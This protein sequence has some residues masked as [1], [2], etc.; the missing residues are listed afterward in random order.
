MTT[1]ITGQDVRVYQAM[2]IR[3]ALNMYIRTGMKANTAYTPKNMLATAGHIVGKAYGKA[4]NQT[5]Q[6][7]VFDLTAWIDSQRSEG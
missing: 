6:Q 5:M 7:A 4:T 1:V 2:A 3:S